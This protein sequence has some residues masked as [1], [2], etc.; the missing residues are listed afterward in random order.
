[1]RPTLVSGVGTASASVLY[2][3]PAT[4]IREVAP[5]IEKLARVGFLAKALLYITIGT[6]ATAAALRLGGTPATGSRGAMAKLINAPFGEVLIVA[7]AIGLF[8]YAAWRLV[9]GIRDPEGHGTSL[10]GIAMRG[11]SIGAALV[12]AALGVSAV[13]LAAGD[14]SAARDGTAT[15]SWTARAL[16]STA[17]TAALS[18]TAFGFI[19]YGLY[20]LYNAYRAKLDK[21]LAL[22][23]LSPA[24]RRFVIGASRFGIAAR[25]VVFATVGVLLM[26]AVANRDPREARGL[27]AALLELFELGRLPFIVVATGLVAYG[28]YQLINARFRRIRVA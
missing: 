23:R 16:E 14:I 20:Q 28:I 8:G 24:A 27:K 7:I 11:R 19:V 12:H 22:E 15:Q 26:R 9:E 1:M 3:R 6:L 4:A 13:K 25:G 10:T 18:L 5:W 2:M 17:G 21:R